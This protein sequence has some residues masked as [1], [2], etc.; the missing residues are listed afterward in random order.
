MPKL[1]LRRIE[2]WN[3]SKQKTRIQGHS[4][5]LH[6][7]PS[8]M[9]PGNLCSNGTSPRGLVGDR[10]LLPMSPR[11]VSGSPMLR[12]HREAGRD[13]PLLQ[14]SPLGRPGS[15]AALTSPRGPVGTEDCPTNLRVAYEEYTVAQSICRE[16]SGLHV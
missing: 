11:P 12:H 4:E 1:L 7:M 2:H 9:I 6:Q 8:S 3:R 10:P 5:F 16:K 13:R 14:P 15:L